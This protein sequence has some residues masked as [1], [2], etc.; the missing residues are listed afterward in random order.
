MVLAFSYSSGISRLFASSWSWTVLSELL[1][2]IYTLLLLGICTFWALQSVPEPCQ[3]QQP[4]C[5]AA[6][7]RE[8]S[9]RTNQ[10]L[11]SF[12]DSSIPPFPLLHLHHWR[13]LCSVKMSQSSVTA[14]SLWPFPCTW[15]TFPDFYTGRKIHWF[16]THFPLV[17]VH[18]QVLSSFHKS[19]LCLLLCWR[20]K[21]S[22]LPTIPKSFSVSS[23][24]FLCSPTPNTTGGWGLAAHTCRKSPS[25]CRVQNWVSTTKPRQQCLKYTGLKAIF[26]GV[27]F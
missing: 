20:E 5:S 19:Q 27:D 4:K 11:L 12:T 15:G 13:Q 2:I 23:L 1:Y 9:S 22:C 14:F 7:E 24:F 17:D 8:E 16:S 21:H 3:P 6:R 25:P 10:I 18:Y 26:F